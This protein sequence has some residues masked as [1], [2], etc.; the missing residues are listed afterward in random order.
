MN[1][2]LMYILITAFILLLFTSCASY[3]VRGQL[4]YNG[5]EIDKKTSVQPTFWFRNED[6]GSSVTPTI[7]YSNGS[8]KI[9]GLPPGNYGISVNIDAN[10]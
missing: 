6:K 3:Q 1:R 7:K 10:P 9:Y 2:K 5:T 4:T 8:V